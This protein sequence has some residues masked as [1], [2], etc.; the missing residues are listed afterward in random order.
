MT[1]DEF[2]EILSLEQVAEFTEI[3]AEMAEKDVKPDMD[4]YIGV[5]GY[6]AE[7]NHFIALTDPEKEDPIYFEILLDYAWVDRKNSRDLVGKIKEVNAFETKADMELCRHIS[8]ITAI[9][10]IHDTPNLN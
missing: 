3:L 6:V 9:S 10:S 7:F 5:I 2:F 4:K 1:R 8:N